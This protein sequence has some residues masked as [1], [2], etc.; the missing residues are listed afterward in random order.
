MSQ[1]REQVKAKQHTVWEALA[2]KSA[3][4][5]D[6]LLHAIAMANLMTEID[7]SAMRNVL[8]AELESAM[9]HAARAHGDPHKVALDKSREGRKQAD[10]LAGWK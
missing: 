8:I 9:Y 3:A 10:K 2:E 6:A 4:R 1:S 7:K 5:V